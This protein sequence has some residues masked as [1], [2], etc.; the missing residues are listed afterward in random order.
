MLL[1]WQYNLLVFLG[2]LALVLVLA[3]AVAYAR[4]RDARI[5][6]DRRQMFIQQTFPLQALYNDVVK[7]LAQMAL[8]SNDRQVLDMLAARGISVSMNAAAASAGPASAAAVA[9]KAAK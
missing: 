1:K 5:E 3:D 4:N 9:G 7:A 6:L 8:R 2:G